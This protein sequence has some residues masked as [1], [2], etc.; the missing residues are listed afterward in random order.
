MHTAFRTM[1]GREYPIVAFS[2]CR[3]VVAA[4]SRAG[5]LGVLGASRY[6]PEELEAEL[7]W[8]DRE[9]GDAGYG[10]DFLL[11]AR[12]DTD[13]PPPDELPVEHREFVDTLLE[14]YEVPEL[15][16]WQRAEVVAEQEKRRTMVS[17]ARE[18][19]E[20]AAGRP[21]RLYASALGAPPPEFVAAA[22]ERGAIIGGLAGSVRHAERQKAAGVD[23]VVAAGT[24]AGGHCG[25]I[26]TM[27]L[28]P[29]VVDVMGSTPVLAAGGIGTGRQ[30]AAALAL[31]A[32]GVW[33]GSIWLSTRE[34]ETHPVVLDKMLRAG[35]G[36]AVRSRASTGKFARQLRSAW[37]DEWADPAGPEPL[38][39]PDQFRLIAEAKARIDR[40]A[41]RSPGA[42][43]L[44][45]Y[46]VG[47][48]VGRMTRTTT[49][50]E[51]VE[52]FVH[53]YVEAV[54]RLGSIS[55]L[56]PG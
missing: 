22:H 11:P 27:V 43:K 23:F 26:A 52:G 29:D 40:S 6:T 56:D 17:A 54:E 34:A 25:E 21:I 10:L 44:V 41:H 3:D 47:Q 50:R 15:T 9:A 7:D 30:M 55:G 1:I 51:V 45:N 28:T 20:L 2:H 24:E 48:L 36:D 53:E 31:G 16:D 4:V 14:R 8:L 42:E 19:W 37:T 49:V 39:M 12:F 46:Y 13:P 38:G 5:G 35:A 32:Q 33:T 18:M